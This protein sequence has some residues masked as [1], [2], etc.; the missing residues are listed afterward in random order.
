MAGPL[1]VQ[2][3]VAADCRKLKDEIERRTCILIRNEIV[4][5]WPACGQNEKAARSQVLP[6]QFS[7]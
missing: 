3:A 2:L 4:D 5:H 7:R 6:S 1:L